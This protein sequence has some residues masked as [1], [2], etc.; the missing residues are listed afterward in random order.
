M[1]GKQWRVFLLRE[2]GGIGW[3]YADKHGQASTA[4]PVLEA[5]V[6]PHSRDAVDLGKK[7]ECL[8]KRAAAEFT[9]TQTPAVR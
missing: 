2:D 8:G 3:T 9:R 1:K 6:Y 4:T 7:A 5:E